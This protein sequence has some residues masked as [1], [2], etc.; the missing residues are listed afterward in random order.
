MPWKL[1]ALK[2]VSWGESK[3]KVGRIDS[4]GIKDRSDISAT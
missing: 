2:T 3:G 4:L 1:K